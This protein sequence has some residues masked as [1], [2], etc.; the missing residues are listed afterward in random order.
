MEKPKK[1]ACIFLKSVLLYILRLKI[2]AH[3]PVAQLDRV[4]DYESEGR[5]FESLPARQNKQDTQVGILF[6]FHL[7]N[8]GIKIPFLIDRS[9]RV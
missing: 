1:R 6:L 9:L 8:A 7:G 3:A 2:A 4:S 5:E